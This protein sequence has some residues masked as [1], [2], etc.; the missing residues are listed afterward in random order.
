MSA[1]VNV[2]F[3][4]V[5]PR[6]APAP[7]VAIADISSLNA[8]GDED[9]LVRGGLVINLRR[10]EFRQRVVPGSYLV[11]L[12]IP[13][14]QLVSKRVRV[15][16]DEGE[17]E[18][19]F[20]PAGVRAVVEGVPDDE[21]LQIA[22]H[23]TFPTVASPNKPQSKD[24]ADRDRWKAKVIDSKVATLANLPGLAVREVVQERQGYMGVAKLQAR[25]RS[26]V[27]LSEERAKQD[28]SSYLVGDIDAFQA[29]KLYGNVSEL[30][31]HWKT[32]LRKEAIIGPRAQ[33]GKG[34]RYFALSYRATDTLSPLQVACMPGRWETQEGHLARVDATYYSRRI[35]TR[36]RRGLLLEVDDPDFGGLIDFLQQGELSGA[37]QVVSRSLQILFHKWRNPYAAAAAGYVLV[38]AGLASANDGENWEQW[39]LNLAS[40]YTG[41]P[42]GA[43]LYTT[44]LLQGPPDVVRRLN[45]SGAGTAPFREA[46]DAALE[47]VRRGPPLFRYGLKLMSTNL[48]I[49]ANEDVAIGDKYGQLIAAQRYVRELSLRV[50][51]GQPFCVFD[52]AQ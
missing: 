39:I 42:D 10:G 17:P 31:A 35:G 50:D 47:A 8:R 49:L 52:V 46:L 19:V 29:A 5:L 38:S 6:N 48:D 4:R 43:I 32:P 30:R 41:L 18:L 13:T 9:K 33:E 27:L 16:E 36:T 21:N 3:S 24:S 34:A 1:I 14:G 2:D 26:E 11:R 28:V 40:R 44:L 51:P 7:R 12:R 45:F 15:K 25:P 37:V 23:K 20:V 22:V